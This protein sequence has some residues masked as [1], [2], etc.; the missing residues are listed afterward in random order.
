MLMHVV[1]NFVYPLIGGMVQSHCAL[2]IAIMH[3]LV[4]KQ[5]L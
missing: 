2:S 4:A 1:Q 5:C 3:D